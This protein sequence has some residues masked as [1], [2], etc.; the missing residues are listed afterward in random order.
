MLDKINS[1]TKVVPSLISGLCIAATVW[2][3][4]LWRGSAV[5]RLSQ[6]STDYHA[7]VGPFL[8][9]TISKHVGEN[10]YTASITLKSG[11]LWF[12]LC[13]IAAGVLVGILLQKRANH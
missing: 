12:G 10:G 6:F 13:C 1:H 9:T 7:S 8:L 11:L 2:I 5:V 4:L 3:A